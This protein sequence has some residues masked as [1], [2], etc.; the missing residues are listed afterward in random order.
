MTGHSVNCRHLSA[1]SWPLWSRR[2]T[3]STRNPTTAAPATMDATSTRRRARGPSS[4]A[5]AVAEA[6][7]IIV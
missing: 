4:S 5:N 7:P 1:S 3:A 2:R 6:A